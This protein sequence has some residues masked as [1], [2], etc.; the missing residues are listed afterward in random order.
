MIPL[1]APNATM[2]LGVLRTVETKEIV[3]RGWKRL[4][5]VVDILVGVWF[6]GQVKEL[7]RYM[8]ESNDNRHGYRY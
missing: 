1:A 3:V 6:R 2:L 4:S 7:R 8:T 5:E